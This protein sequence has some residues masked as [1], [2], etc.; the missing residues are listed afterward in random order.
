MNNIK[1][2]VIIPVYNCESYIEQCLESVIKQTLKEIE[3]ICVDDG[4]SDNS[5]VILQEYAEQYDCIYV[6]SQQNSGAGTARNLGLRYAAG[7][8][9]AFLDADDFYLDSDAL[10][11]MYAICKQE[12]VSV[13]GSFGRI[14]EGN[15]YR[16]ANFYD[17]KGLNVNKVHLYT[18]FQMDCGYTTFL[19]ARRIIEENKIRFPEYRRFQDPPFLIRAMYYGEKFAMADTQLY[20]YRAPNL[21]NRMNQEKIIDLLKGLKDNL[22]FASEHN[23]DKLFT[24]TL[25]RLEY[26]YL[27]LILHNMSKEPS[28]KNNEIFFLLQSVN[29]LAQDYYKDETY[30]IRVLQ[31]MMSKAASGCEEYEDLLNRKIQGMNQIAIYGAGKYAKNFLRYL[32]KKELLDKV[33]YIVVSSR[34]DNDEKL[35]GIEVVDID[36]FAKKRENEYIFVAVGAM[37]HEEIA[38]KLRQEQLY[39]FELMD[40]AFLGGIG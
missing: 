16:T 26:D 32:E 10:E 17:T 24:E 40:D 9:V 28:A 11:K 7:E 21:I 6:Y 4:S 23:L 29:K 8:Y 14:L 3:I 38:E 37:N 31:L 25:H 18:D 22:F 27:Y 5:L 1:V 35:Y 19:F 34:N 36:T 20:C 12:D 15:R 33:T 13:C 39:E 30:L 2:S